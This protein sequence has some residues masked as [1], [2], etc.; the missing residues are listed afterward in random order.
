MV[1]SSKKIYL[2]AA[3]GIFG[4]SPK[5]ILGG[6]PELKIMA[7]IE[8]VYISADLAA[9]IRPADWQRLA[10]EI[11]RRLD[12]AGGFVVLHGADN[13]L[14]TASALSFMLADLPVP[15]I[16]SGG[17]GEA[18]SPRFGEAGNDNNMEIRANLIN[19]VQTASFDIPEVCLMFGNR[20]LRANQA[21][22]ARDESM[23]L[24]FAPAGG[25]LGRIDFS[26]R[27]F[28]KNI[29]RTKGK[30]KLLDRLTTELEIIN[31]SP[32][33]E[34]NL[35]R[36]VSGGAK[37]I[38]INAGD[39]QNLPHDLLAALAKLD[40]EMPVMIWSSQAGRR[41]FGLKDNIFIN[42]MTWEA[43]LVKFMWVLAQTKNF[44]E[45]SELMRQDLAGEITA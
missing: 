32:L 7:E 24:F 34:A 39:H 41:P 27:I 15:V 36:P 35:P 28:E 3:S 23:N 5:E 16:F 17:L 22:R 2:L 38:A 10:S 14:Y 26:L 31:L 13:L 33:P 8:P 11:Y 44:R 20:L 25:V 19:A 18:G 9:D 29:K 42:N 1:K 37:G 43:S 4:L 40:P 12:D 21:G 6:I 30:A 45:T